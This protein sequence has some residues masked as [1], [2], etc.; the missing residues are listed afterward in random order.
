MKNIMACEIFAAKKDRAMNPESLEKKSWFRDA[1]KDKV[2]FNESLAWGIFIG[3]LVQKYV[4]STGMLGVFW[5][6]F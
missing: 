6:L 2:L 3:L 4:L 1:I 5:R